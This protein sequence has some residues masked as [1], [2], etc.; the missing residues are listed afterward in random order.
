MNMLLFLLDLVMIHLLL[1]EDFELIVAD[2]PDVYYL[3]LFSMASVILV[4]Y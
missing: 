3:V 4:S 1:K 2:D